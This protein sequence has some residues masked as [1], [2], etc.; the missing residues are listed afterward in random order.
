MKTDEQVKRVCPLCGA[1]YTERPAV[2]R[3]NNNLLICP[4]CGIKEALS[5]L[6]LSADEQEKIVSIIHESSEGYFEI[7]KER[8]TDRGKSSA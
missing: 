1:S 4:D 8:L 7:A 6:G 2:S 3:V 5:S